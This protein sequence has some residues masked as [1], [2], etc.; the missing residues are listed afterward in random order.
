MDLNHVANATDKRRDKHE[1]G[2]AGVERDRTLA[3]RFQQLN[4]LCQDTAPTAAR[5]PRRVWFPR[6]ELGKGKYV[7]TRLCSPL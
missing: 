7:L 6:P 3:P 1:F 5:R 2:P 4:A